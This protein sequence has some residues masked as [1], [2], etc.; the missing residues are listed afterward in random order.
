MVIRAGREIVTGAAA[1]MDAQFALEGRVKPEKQIFLHPQQLLLQLLTLI[2]LRI[3]HAYQDHHG[4]KITV[5]G[6]H[7]QMAKEY[8][9]QEHATQVLQ[10]RTNLIV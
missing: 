10:Y 8:A 7:V 5:T 2:I 6:A 3:L 1:P 9:Q 4:K